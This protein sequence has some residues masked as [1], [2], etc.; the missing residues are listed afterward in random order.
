MSCVELDW[1]GV[2]VEVD[3]YVIV[4]VYV[5]DVFEWDE[6]FL[7]VGVYFGLLGVCLV[8]WLEICGVVD[9]LVELVVDFLFV[10]CFFE[11]FVGVS[12]CCVVFV[13]GWVWFVEIDV[14]DF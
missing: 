5:V 4:V 6:D 1:I 9:Y 12:I 7:W 3:F 11:V 8:G 14:V 10:V 2:C 13:V